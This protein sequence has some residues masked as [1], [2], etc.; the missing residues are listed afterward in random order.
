MT[1][2]TTSMGKRHSPTHGL[3]PRCGG[4]SWHLQKKRCGKCSYPAKKIRGYNWSR[5]ALRRK[6]TGTGRMR[7]LSKVPGKFKNNF[8]V[9]PQNQKKEHQP[10]SQLSQKQCVPQ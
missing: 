5:K 8:R 3:C 6:S 4:R 9:K 10:F 1:K 2:G 7:Y